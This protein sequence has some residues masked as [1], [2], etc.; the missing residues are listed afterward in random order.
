MAPGHDG[1]HGPGGLI[2]GQ[3]GLEQEKHPD[4]RVHDRAQ[5][6]TDWKDKE[7]IW[8]QSYNACEVQGP[9]PSNPNAY[10]EKMAQI[11]FET[12]RTPAK[13][14][15]QGSDVAVASCFYHRHHYILQQQGR[16]HCTSKRASLCPTPSS[17]IW[18]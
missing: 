13:Y 1:G 14:I 8:H 9:L 4:P 6:V 5:L 17:C 18:I 10:S 3:Q 7:E 2:H 15:N 11:L 16:P 12:F